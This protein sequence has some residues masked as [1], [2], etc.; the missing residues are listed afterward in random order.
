MNLLQT[1]RTYATAA[2]AMKAL[3]IAS[4]KLGK[5]IS[6]VRH[7]IAVNADGRFA[8]VVLGVNDKKNDSNNGFMFIGITWVG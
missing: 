6:D 1:D 2:N 5:D 8:P 3:V 7:L 4:K